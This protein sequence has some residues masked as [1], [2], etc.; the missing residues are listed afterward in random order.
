[1]EKFQASIHAP[2]PGHA[3]VMN[4]FAALPFVSY[5]QCSC[6]SI[7]D[8]REEQ[9]SVLVR[10]YQETNSSTSPQVRISSHIAYVPKSARPPVSPSPQVSAF[11]ALPGPRELAVRA[12]PWRICAQWVIHYIIHVHPRVTSYRKCLCSSAS[13]QEWRTLQKNRKR[14]QAELHHAEQVLETRSEQLRN[15]KAELK[16]RRVEVM[17]RN[18]RRGH[19]RLQAL[20]HGELARLASDLP[21]A[22]ARRPACNAHKTSHCRMQLIFV[23]RR[24]DT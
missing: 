22:H 17:L 3:S 9:R 18:T 4:I 12:M 11:P 20:P 23:H 24:S 6:C 21:P 7:L 10:G 2:R 5:E 15:A 8:K 13:Q 1:M 16:T 19:C 14:V